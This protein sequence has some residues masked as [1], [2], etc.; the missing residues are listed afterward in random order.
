MPAIIP[1]VHDLVM[2]SVA[3]RKRVSISKVV[4][5]VGGRGGRLV[6][7]EKVSSQRFL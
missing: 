5:A 6:S 2:N 1:R 7:L 3:A 4:R